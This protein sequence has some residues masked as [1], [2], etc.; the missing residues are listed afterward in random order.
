MDNLNRQILDHVKA[1][2]GAGVEWFPRVPTLEVAVRMATQS[3]SIVVQDSPLAALQTGDAVLDERRLALTT[4]AN[5]VKACTRCAE[6]CSTRTQTVFGVGNPLAE[7]C[8]L[9][10]APGK[11]EDAKGEPF[12]GE[13]GKL[14]NK[15]LA[16]SGFS[17][18]EIYILNILK[19]RPPGNRTP[20]ANEAANCREFLDRQLE[21]IA[22]KYIVALGGCAAT[23]LLQTTQ[24][25]AKLRGRFHAYRDS[26]V[27]VTYHPAYLLP[28]KDP[29]KKKEVW[30]DMK[31]LV[32]EMGRSLPESPGSTRG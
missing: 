31:F 22:P 32:K 25:I 19:C 17:R 18:D 5:E 16:A 29:S 7:V 28:H 30:E 8:F 9:G 10:E 15:I 6:L 1:L 23:N 27:L 13:A 4:L 11:D 3:G 12:V 21:V 14:L 20:L 24:S 26:K 2:H